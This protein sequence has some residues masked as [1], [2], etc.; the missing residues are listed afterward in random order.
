METVRNYLRLIRLERALS[1][2][3]GVLFTGI[4]VGDLVA[5]QSVYVIACLAVFFSAV[6]N[7]GLNDYSDIETDRRN[8]RLDRP[9]AQGQLK[10]G[11]ALLTAI[12]S[13]ALALILSFLL[14]PVARLLIFL[15]LPTS[16]LYNLVLKRYL[17]LKNAFIGLANVGV[18][19]IGSL[20]SDVVLEPLA[21]YIAVIG[22]FFSLSYETMLDIADMEG[23]RAKGVDTLPNRFGVRNAMMFSLLFGFGAIIVDP[24]PF[25]IEIDSRLS[26]D[27]LFLSLILLPVFNRLFISKSLLKDQSPENIFR[28]KK[29]IFRNLQLG[30]L[31]YL[32]GFL[33]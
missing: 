12:I 17:L 20:V 23:D 28:L 32:I 25:F 11:T 5:F 8:D 24:L 18:V 31:C 26:G 15:G 27:Y 29:R 22:F 7:F 3:F 13:T 10:P 9:L 30:C 16:L 1:A 14:N 6:A 2:T 33:L 21:L 19:L 4:V